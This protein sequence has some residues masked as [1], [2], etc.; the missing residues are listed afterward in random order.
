MRQSLALVLFTLPAV[1]FG[2]YSQFHFQHA[3]PA[4]TLIKTGRILDVTS[5]KYLDHQSILTEG[6]RIKEVGPWDQVQAHAPKDAINI[7]LSQATVLPGLIDCHAHPF[8]SM[9]PHMSGGEGLTTAIALM[10]PTLRVFTGA[11]NLR[12]DLEAGI[13]SVRIVG[14]S[15]VDG[16]ISLRDAINL[17]LVQGPRLQASGRKL[18]PLGGQSMYLQPA[19]AKPIL[20]Q[21]YREVSGPDD[22]RRAVRENLAGGVDWIKIAM[23][24]G[25]G[26][27]WKFRYMDP[28]DARAVIEEAHRVHL[29]VAVH[30][31]DP[32]AIQTAIDAGADSIEHAYVATEQQLQRMKDKGIFL[33][34]ND[35]PD[36]GG[37]PESKRRLQQAMKIGVKI[38]IGTDLWVPFPGKTYGQNSLMDLYACMTKACRTW[39]SSAVR[40]SPARR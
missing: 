13:T 37:S 2:Q 38:A 24:A 34:A 19:L 10:S 29:K 6:G 31:M 30:A 27:M 20:E 23:D 36:N 8:V 26:P 39:T 28:V 4:P 12:E 25:A 1:A 17:G 32:D 16:D 33:V 14:H 7:D 11:H 21:E 3:S 40:R 9:D 22:A 5:G 35:M 18:T 15:G